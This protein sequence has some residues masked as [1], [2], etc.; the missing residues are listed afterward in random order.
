MPD[1]GENIKQSLLTS[2]NT[3]VFLDGSSRTS[4][5]LHSAGV[6]L[7][8]Y[9]PGWRWSV[10]A[11][12]QTGKPAGK[13][14]GYVIS[15]RFIISDSAGNEISV[16]PGEAFEMAPNGDSWVDGDEACVALDFMAME[17]LIKYSAQ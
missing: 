8:T 2:T 3:R 4:E 6:G 17:D 1:P 5:L 13:H 12:A 11:G 14:I 15:G 7:G 9:R 10:H 16:G